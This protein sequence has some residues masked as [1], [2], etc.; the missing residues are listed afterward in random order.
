MPRCEE[1]EDPVVILHQ[2]GN[3]QRC[4]A[5]ISSI[6]Y[7]LCEDCSSLFEECVVCGDAIWS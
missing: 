4:N 2:M 5:S 6:T 1:H 7:E 3:C